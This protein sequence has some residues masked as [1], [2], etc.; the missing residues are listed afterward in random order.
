MYVATERHRNKFFH[1]FGKIA[2]FFRSKE[3]RICPRKAKKAINFPLDWLLNETIRRWVYAHQN[4][5]VFM[6]DV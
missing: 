2:A 4:I 6:Q 1:A 5:P 3:K